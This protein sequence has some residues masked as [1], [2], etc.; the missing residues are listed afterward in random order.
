MCLVCFGG[1]AHADRIALP[2]IKATI[3]LPSGWTKFEAKGLEVAYR[4]GGAVLVLHRV[5]VPNPD[6]W[7]AKTRDAYLA[8]IERGAIASAGGQRRVA[9]K[10]G[11]VNGVPFLDLELARDDKSTLVMRVLV[12]RTFALAIVIAV[13]GGGDLP[14]DRAR[15]IARSFEP[16]KPDPPPEQKP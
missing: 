6:A 8:E 2:N 15:A 3:D 10:V 7:R 4:K 9:R 16:P 14:I 1:L 11:E 13:P 12:Y 5:P